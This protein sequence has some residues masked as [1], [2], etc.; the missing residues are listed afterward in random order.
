MHSC[1]CRRWNSM[2]TVGKLIK[3]SSCPQFH[4]VL[5]CIKVDRF[6]S[7]W[8]CS[9]LIS[10]QLSNNMCMVSIPGIYQSAVS[11]TLPSRWVVDY[12]RFKALSSLTGYQNLIV[13]AILYGPAIF[14]AKLDVLLL[15]YQLFQIK[16]RARITIAL[17]LAVII[18]Q[19]L[20]TMIGYSVLCV[21]KPGQSWLIRTSG[22]SCSVTSNLFEVVLGVVS[23]FSDLFVI[24][25]PLPIIWKLHLSTRK[26]ISVSIVFITGL[27]WVFSLRRS[28]HILATNSDS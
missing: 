5:F 2:S 24:Y 11:P 15:Y 3:C 9:V 23:V 12:P 13:L 4:T 14:F 8:S 27:L 26:K 7:S 6:F 1:C 17:G 16:K 21:P 25:I 19:C 18:V 10:F 28:C 22:R 20:A